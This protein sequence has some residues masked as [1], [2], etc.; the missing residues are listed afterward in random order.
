M[1]IYAYR[2]K[3]TG[4]Y[5]RFEGDIRLEHKE[6]GDVFVCPETYE[7]VYESQLPEIS[8]KEMVVELPPVKIDGVWVQQLSTAPLPERPFIPPPASFPLNQKPSR[9]NN[10][11]PIFPTE[12]KG[13]I[14][15]TR[16]G[17]SI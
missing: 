3:S 13:R 16:L 4:E 7:V 6:I 5:P 10:A 14:E 17:P 8:N 15:I 12:A 2:K 9:P 1:K 11:T